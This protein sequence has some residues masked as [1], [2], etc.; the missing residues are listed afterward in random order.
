M[1]K[2]HCFI[3]KIIDFHEELKHY[4][5]NKQKILFL[6]SNLPCCVFVGFLVLLCFFKAFEIALQHTQ[7]AS[8]SD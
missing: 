3:K 6:I 7:G 4:R 2:T 8:L 5:K 1:T